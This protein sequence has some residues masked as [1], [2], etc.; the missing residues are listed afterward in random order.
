MIRT[1]KSIFMIIGP[2]ERKKQRYRKFHF[3]AWLICIVFSRGFKFRNYSIR[4]FETIF[5]DRSNRTWDMVKIQGISF[6]RFINSYRKFLRAEKATISIY[7]IW[8]I[9]CIIRKVWNFEK[10][11]HY[12]IR[13]NTTIFINNEMVLKSISADS[14]DY[15]NWK[16]K[17]NDMPHNEKTWNGLNIQYWNHSNIYKSRKQV[18]ILFNVYHTIN[19]F[20]Q[21]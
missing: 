9:E 13:K 18:I 8:E 21:N 12:L 16:L 19:P 3:C 17:I 10:A 5:N 2:T 15:R 14:Q 1:T 7:R 20:N 6:L 11:S 4:T